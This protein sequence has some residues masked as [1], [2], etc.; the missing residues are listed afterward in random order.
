M[1]LFV[2]IITFCSNNNTHI[3]RLVI[4]SFIKMKKT[5]FSP[6]FL[7]KDLLE[8]PHFLIVN[9]TDGDCVY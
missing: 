7:K 1:Q 2:A 5:R 9:I 4:S 3:L 8:N 6:D